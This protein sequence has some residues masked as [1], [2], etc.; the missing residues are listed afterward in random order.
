MAVE[1]PVAR[2]T[3]ITPEIVMASRAYWKG[4]LKLSGLLRN[5]ST[6]SRPPSRDPRV[7]ACAHRD[8]GKFMRDAVLVAFPRR[9]SQQPTFVVMGPGSRPGRRFRYDALPRHTSHRFDFQQPNNVIASVS[10]AIHGAANA[11]GEEWIASSHPPSPEG[12]LRRTRV[13]LPMTVVRP[14]TLRPRLHLR[15]G[16]RHQLV[17]LHPDLLI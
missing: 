6:S 12:G 13:L 4:S 5:L 17:H 1:V 3:H 14:R 9:A 8:A 15:D 16:L 7:S 11:A 2:K 10:E